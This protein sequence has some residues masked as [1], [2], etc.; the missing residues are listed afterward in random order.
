MFVNAIIITTVTI[1]TTVTFTR[2]FMRTHSLYLFIYIFLLGPWH[3]EA[4]RPGVELEVQPLAYATTKA[5]P[6]LSHICNLCLRMWQHRI[7]NPLCEARDGTCILTVTSWVLNPLSH[8]RN[9]YISFSFFFSFLFFCFLRPHLQHMEVGVK[10][11]LQM[12]VYATAI[13]TATRD[14]SGIC[15]LHH[16]SWQH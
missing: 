11:E 13:A 15:D 10:L 3:M 14:V 2:T 1:T 8:K 4:P 7:P 12:L 9:A 6:D 5:T 16:S